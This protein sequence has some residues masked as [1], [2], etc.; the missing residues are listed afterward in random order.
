[1]MFRLIEKNVETE[2]QVLIASWMV[3]ISLY[4]VIHFLIINIFQRFVYY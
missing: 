4:T 1:M 2:L 3:N